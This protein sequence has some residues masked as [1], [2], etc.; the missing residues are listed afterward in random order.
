[1]KG[2]VM[3]AYAGDFTKALNRFHKLV[4]DGGKEKG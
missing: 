3:G 4:G 1:M 2:F